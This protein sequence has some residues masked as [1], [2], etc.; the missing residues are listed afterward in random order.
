MTPDQRL[1]RPWSA[2][3]FLLVDGRRL[4]YD[5]HPMY[6]I[7]RVHLPGG[8]SSTVDELL[9]HGFV[10]TLPERIRFD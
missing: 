5:A 9:L 4:V 3:E 1:T 7:T 10:V 6:G 2:D 8:T